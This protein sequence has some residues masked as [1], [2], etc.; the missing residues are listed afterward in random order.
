VEA[1]G[2]ITGGYMEPDEVKEVIIGQYDSLINAIIGLCQ[3]AIRRDIM[4]ASEN[5]EMTKTFE[6]DFIDQ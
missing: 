5:W 4:S 6:S 1:Q 2:T 3:D